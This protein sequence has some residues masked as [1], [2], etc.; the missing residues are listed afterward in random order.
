MRE[1]IIFSRHPRLKSWLSAIVPRLP[2]ATDELRFASSSE[3]LETCLLD[4]NKLI[5]I[6]Y[7][8]QEHLDLALS[9][10]SAQVVL[11]GDV[12]NADAG[13]VWQMRQLCLDRAQIHAFI[14]YSR[15]AE[16]YIPVLRSAL[17]A[18]DGAGKMS[19]I[20][21]MSLKLNALV[22]QNLLELHR[23]KRLHEKLVP[24]R[25]EKLKGVSIYSKF[26]A[27]E[28]SGGEFFDTVCFDKDVLILMASSTSYVASS[29]I[30]GHF[31]DLRNSKTFDEQSFEKFI[32]S[33]SYELKKYQHNEVELTLI[34]LDIHSMQV[35]G[36]NFGAGTIWKNGEA[37]NKPNELELNPIFVEK[38]KVDF[39]ISRGEQILIRSAGYAK[40]LQS[41]AL[42]QNE[43][44]VEFL[45]SI[46]NKSIYEKMSELFFKLKKDMTKDFLKTDASVIIIEVDKNAIL[47]V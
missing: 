17:L 44:W 32:T 47:Q 35:S 8:W 1:T 23:L 2:L 15:D 3:N 26:A 30:L 43:K 12:Q 27:G 6:D 7:S 18:R 20:K 46:E 36:Y 45:K 28:S 25:S 24:L 38:A 21:E 42:E 14:D 34:T 33:L 31:E 5:L 13:Q 41:T 4:A 9:K 19:E 40:N 37:L 11:L 10:A 29:A 16:F 39:K 22:T